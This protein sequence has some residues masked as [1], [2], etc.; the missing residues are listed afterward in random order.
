MNNSN[1]TTFLETLYDETESQENICLISGLPLE[2][3]FIKLYCNHT[4]NYKPIFTEISTQK[5]NPNYLEVIK[6]KMK[7]IK[8]P[9]CRK[10][11]NHLLPNRVN[12]PSINGVNYP[13]K[14]CMKQY[15]CKSTFKSGKRKGMVCGRPSRTE[16]C[17]YHNSI[18]KKTN[19]I[20]RAKCEYILTSGKNSGKN[21]SRNSLYSQHYC[22]QH[23]KIIN[24]NPLSN[25][26]KVSNKLKKKKIIIKTKLAN[27]II[28]LTN[29]PDTGKFY[30]ETALIPDNFIKNN[31]ITI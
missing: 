19:S 3:N 26:E 23:L 30:Q 18:T 28:D 9:Y 7:Q 25:I 10:I 2:E 16:Y 17:C 6:L 1:F 13:I 14:F 24:K 15:N 4:F 11:Q 22:K 27:K 12:Y 5:I 29:K 31:K 8:C 20:S 21:C